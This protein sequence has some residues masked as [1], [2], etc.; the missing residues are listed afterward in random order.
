MLIEAAIE[1]VKSARKDPKVE[2]NMA[3]YLE[4]FNKGRCS[5]C[6]A[7]AVILY[8]MND[9]QVPEEYLDHLEDVRE[10]YEVSTAL[11]LQL[12][13]TIR[14]GDLFPQYVEGYFNRLDWS[15]W[16][17]DVKYAREHI[18]QAQN[19]WMMEGDM[20][21]WRAFLNKLKQLRKA[22]YDQR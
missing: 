18:T 5:V 4:K 22:E 11:K 6:V 21:G 16:Y 9:G 2:L 3:R 1:D 7:G 15:E 13:D 8:S 14:D 17:E 12:L 19:C 10:N 20:R